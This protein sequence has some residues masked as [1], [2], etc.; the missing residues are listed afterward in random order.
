MRQLYC[1]F[2]LGF[3]NWQTQHTLELGNGFW[4]NVDFEEKNTDILWGRAPQCL[5]Y[6]CEHG[7]FRVSA[8]VAWQFQIQIGFSAVKQGLILEWEAEENTHLNRLDVRKPLVV[9]ISRR[10]EKLRL[11]NLVLKMTISNP[12]LKE[13][14]SN[15]SPGWTIRFFFGGWWLGFT[16]RGGQYLSVMA[17]TSQL[18]SQA[19]FLLFTSVVCDSERS[20][21]F[22]MRICRLRV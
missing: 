22:L 13:V 4:S 10:S 11:Y 20:E 21:K 18:E 15:A 2:E 5:G 14:S 3:W 9:S 12:G 17:P 6:K 16:E 8:Q 7:C 1:Q 19:Y